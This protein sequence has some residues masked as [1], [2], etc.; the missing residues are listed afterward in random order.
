MW[1]QEIDTKAAALDKD[2]KDLMWSRCMLSDDLKKK[3]RRD[4][5]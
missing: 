3:R 2:V 4:I 1:Q 5:Q